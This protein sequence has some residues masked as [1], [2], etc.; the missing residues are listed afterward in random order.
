MRLYS[1]L[2]RFRCYYF[3]QN[4]PSQLLLRCVYRADVGRHAPVRQMSDDLPGV[5]LF[6]GRLLVEE[7][8]EAFEVLFLTPDGQGEVAV[9]RAEFMVDLA[10][11]FRDDFGGNFGV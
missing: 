9:R 11:E 7:G 3:Q 1:I 6:L 2:L 5:F 4:I 10:V 8:S